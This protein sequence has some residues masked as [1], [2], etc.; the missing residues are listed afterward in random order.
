MT[1]GTLLFSVFP[2][3][4]DSIIDGYVKNEKRFESPCTYIILNSNMK[5]F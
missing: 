2:C 3:W 5:T 4:T 1:S